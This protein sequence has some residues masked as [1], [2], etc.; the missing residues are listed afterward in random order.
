MFATCCQETSLLQTLDV[1]VSRRVNGNTPGRFSITEAGHR[2]S[3]DRS[4]QI[5]A[6]P[7]T[8][9]TCEC[10]CVMEQLIMRIQ[11]L[12]CSAVAYAYSVPKCLCVL[13]RDKA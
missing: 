6:T 8:S 9:E 4:N 3:C 1:D 5:A 10:L 11:T 2:P 7:R 12:L 13:G